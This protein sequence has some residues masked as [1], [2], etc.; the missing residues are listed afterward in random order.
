MATSF[1]DWL[2]EL[3][4]EYDAAHKVPVNHIQHHPVPYIPKCS[5]CRAS[6]RSRAARD[7]L[8]SAGFFG[9]KAA[10]V[11]AQMYEGLEELADE[12]GWIFCDDDCGDV[13]CI[14]QRAAQKLQEE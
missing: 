10:H 5:G 6:D 1:E 4:K 12:L 13:P 7:A 14:A 11:A 3:C 9:T 2:R 8:E